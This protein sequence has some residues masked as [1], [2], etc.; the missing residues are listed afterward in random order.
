MMDSKSLETATLKCLK[1][2]DSKYSD[3]KIQSL[4][5]ISGGYSRLTYKV[6]LGYGG[7]SADLILQ[8]LPKGATGLVRVDRKVEND[9]LKFLS[10][11]KG[12]DTP[13]ML[14]SDVDEA[15]FDSATFIF[16]AEKGQTF[17]EVCRQAKQQDYSDLN[18]VVAR[19]GAA[20][21]SQD[22]EDL[23]ASLPRPASWDEYIDKQIEFFRRTESESFTSRPFLRYMAQWLDDN[24]PPPAP[25]SLVH[26]D[27]QVSNMIQAKNKIDSVL[28]DWELSHIGDPR[29]DLGW[30]TMVCGAIPPNILEADVEGFYE[31]YRAKTGLSRDVINPATTAYFLIISSIQTHMG[32][33]KSSDALAESAEQSQ[34]VLAAYYMNLT[35]YQHMN[36]MNA[37]TVVEDTK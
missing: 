34:S 4:T 37:I 33:M 19:A 6:D 11:Q 5:P 23:P 14:A 16:E 36:W 7:N 29:E 2:H 25:L 22:I 24:R 17:I 3:A 27:L 31:E 15:F 21:H 10:Q 8:Y 35:T 18:K 20:V 9:V 1:A 28:V 26:G 12:I 30:F 13:R 32:M